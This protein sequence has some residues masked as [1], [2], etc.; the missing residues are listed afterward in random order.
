MPRDLIGERLRLV[1]RMAP[2]LLEYQRW[3]GEHPRPERG[4]RDYLF[5]VERPRFEP[6]KDDVPVVVPGLQ[7]RARQ[8]RALLACP[9]PPAEVEL[10]GVSRRDAERVLGAMD[11]DRCLLEV[12][13]EAG[14][15]SDVLARFLRAAFGRVVFAPEAVQALETRLSGIEISRFPSPPYAIERPYWENMI[16]VRE[17][18]LARESALGNVEAFIELLTELHVLALMGPT[19][20]SFYRPASPAADRAVAPGALY[21][22]EPRVRQTERG[23]IFLDGPRVNVSL[24]G[25]EGYHRAL[26]EQLGDGEALGE[27]REFAAD[28]LS[29]GAF[30][31]ARSEKDERPGP[32][33]C[34]PRPIEQAHFEY[35]R[36]ELS[37]AARAAREGTASEA[38]RR[39]A[40]FHQGFV[41][42]HP[43][44]CANQ[45]LAMNLSNAVLGRALGAGIP[46]LVLD[47]LALRFG[48]EAYE[49]LVHRAVAAFA[50]PEERPAKRLAILRERAQRSFALIERVSGCADAPAR[51]AVI[52]ADAEA[53]RWALL[54]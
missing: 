34:P 1:S 54:G 42:L 27:G 45:S 39:V 9:E 31:T 14:V 48:T 3:L 35:L 23:A 21:L 2:E 12:R 7:V 5:S 11:G 49:Q 36:A 29:W 10:A 19:L 46:H 13:W 53:A 30:M 4:S 26:A 24:I 28:G 20:A 25:G 51:A 15:G 17:R 18:L 44:R 32:W 33:F 43:F 52:E 37:K 38:I 6:R 16:A 41:R 8:G 47:H 50:L 40:R 22:D